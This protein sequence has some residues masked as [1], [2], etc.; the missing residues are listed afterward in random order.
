MYEAIHRTAAAA[1][2]TE[3]LSSSRTGMVSAAAAHTAAAIG[4]ASQ[5]HIEGAGLTA[6]RHHQASATPAML[7]N[8]TNAIDPAHVFSR[9]QGI[10]R[11]PTARPTIV[12]MPSPTA[13]IAHAAAAISRREGK[14]RINIRTEMG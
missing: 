8:T 1:T 14:T 4:A 7:P 12:D 5:N 2:G 6:F 3:T 13:R 10:G 9:F 11:P